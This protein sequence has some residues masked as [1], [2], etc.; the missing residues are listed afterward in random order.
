MKKFLS[1]LMALFFLTISAQ[2]KASKGGINSIV[3]NS[4][5]NQSRLFVS[6]KDASSGKIVYSINDDRH[7]N[8]ASVQKFLVIIPIIETL[9]PD[10]KFTTELY[11]RGDNSYLLKLGADPYLSSKDLDGIAKNIGAQADKI[12]IDDSILDNKYPPKGWMEEDTQDIYTP[13]YGSYNLDNNLVKFTVMPSVRGQNSLIINQ[14]GYPFIFRNNVITSDTTDIVTERENSP[15]DNV[16]VLTGTVSHPYIET[17]PVTNL[18]RYFN[19]QFKKALENRKIYLKEAF[20]AGS[21]QPSDKFVS[22]VTHDMDKAVDVVADRLNE[23][24]AP[25]LALRAGRLNYQKQLSYQLNDLLAGKVD[26]DSDAED[27]MFTTT[28]DMKKH[29]DMVKGMEA[30]CEQ[31]IKLEKDWH[32][33]SLETE[34]QEKANGKMMFIKTSLKKAEI[35]AIALAI[36][37]LEKNM[38]KTGFFTNIANYTSVKTIKN[39][40]KL[41]S[42]DVNYENIGRLKAELEVAGYVWKLRKI[43]SDIQ[44]TGNLHV[45]MEQIRQMKKRDTRK[46]IPCGQILPLSSVQARS[47]VT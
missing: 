14:S 23:L 38:E 44:N 40:L 7:I 39:T 20:A 42:F 13:R 3:K 18:K 11:S 10:Y 47:A 36:S 21:V 2:A 41:K 12:Y 46:A 1:A 16:I 27:T 15:A 34:E 25:Y 19:F 26:V 31:I 6:V 29:L 35:D 9:G 33:L 43:E 30:K 4:G 37:S 22:K 28:E 32:D 5:V 24:G 17:L 45:L 8:P